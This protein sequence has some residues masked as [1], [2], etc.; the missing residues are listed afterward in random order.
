M[1]ALAIY[2]KLSAVSCILQT[3]RVRE[4]DLFEGLR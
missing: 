3:I 4:S 2:Q 1:S